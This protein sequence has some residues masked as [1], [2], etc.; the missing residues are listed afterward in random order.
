VRHRLW[1]RLAAATVVVGLVAVVIG[2]F[3][4]T[5]WAPATTAST[6]VPMRDASLVVT[7]PGFLELNASSVTVSYRAASPDQRIFL[8]I[9]RASDVDSY[10]A[11][12]SRRSLI[13]LTAVGNP[14]TADAP[15]TSTAPPPER[16]DIWSQT[17]TG[18]G[19]AG[20][21]W[22]GKAGS[23]VLVASAAN[24]K[25]PAGAELTFTWVLP[26]RR[27]NAPAV[28]ALGV[29]LVVSGAIG[30]ALLLAPARME[31]APTEPDPQGSEPVE[32]SRMERTR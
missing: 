15:G 8:G 26:H 11:D 29:L 13:G 17:V 30:L 2:V 28:I 14:I 23:W 21:A 10:V 32:Q 3:M 22:T 18:A 4:A 7:A 9:A 1:S 16:V 20:L 12:A 27:S 31:L 25:K 5:V 24:G 6:R 19:T